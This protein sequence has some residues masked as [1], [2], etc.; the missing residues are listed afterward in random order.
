MQTGQA[1]VTEPIVTSTET[2]MHRLHPLHRTTWTRLRS[3]AGIS[4]QCLAL[5]DLRQ[6]PDEDIRRPVDL[7]GAANATRHA[8]GKDWNTFGEARCLRTADF[9]F[10]QRLACSNL[11]SHYGSLAQ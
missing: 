8:G 6:G 1:T 10:H 3:G 4:A 5:P 7:L 2:G 9:A 11:D